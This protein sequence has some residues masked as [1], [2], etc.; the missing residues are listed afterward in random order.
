MPAGVSNYQHSEETAVGHGFAESKTLDREVPLLF[1]VK[2]VK[3]M[4]QSIVTA[5]FGS[6]NRLLTTVNMLNNIV[7]LVL[8]MWGG[9]T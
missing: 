5:M 1:N 8:V 3:E 4:F 9:T 7:L 2:P 6:L